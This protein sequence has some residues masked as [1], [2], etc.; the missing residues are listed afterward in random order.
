MKALTPG[1]RRYLRHLRSL[2]MKHEQFN[3]RKICEHFGWKSVQASFDY[4]RR[5]IA[6][7]LINRH[8]ERL[9]FVTGPVLTST[10]RQIITKRAA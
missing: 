10:G 7:G 6:K 9:A 3:H 8:G 1:E 2:E 5:L 4:M